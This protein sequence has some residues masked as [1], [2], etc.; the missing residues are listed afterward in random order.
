VLIFNRMPLVPIKNTMDSI[1]RDALHVIF[2]LTGMA[3]DVRVVTV[4]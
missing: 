3:Q 1:E 4:N 2:T